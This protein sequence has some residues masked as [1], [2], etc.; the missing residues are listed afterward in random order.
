MKKL[1]L[2][3]TIVFLTIILLSLLAACSL[4]NDLSTDKGV[5][6]AY[7]REQGAG[8]QVVNLCVERPSALQDVILVG[9]FADD[10]G[11]LIDEMFVDGEL[12]T[13]RE[14][15]AAG[16]THNGWAE[17]SG[18]EALALTWA[19]EVIFVEN[20]VLEQSNGE[21]D[22]TGKS[23]SA[24]AAT[25]NE[26]GS[27]TVGMWVEYS[28]GMLPITTYRLHEIRILADGSLDSNAIVDEYHYTSAL[29]QT[30]KG[31]FYRSRGL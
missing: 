3:K 26:D 5:Q 30:G 12:G 16:L 19:D 20:S 2:P 4:G 11:C 15:T 24:P 14:M 21:F 31:I 8:V 6:R 23:F 9:F 22:T 7:E 27:V 29:G 10:A 1:L 28:G 13:I 18:R 25:L 17:E